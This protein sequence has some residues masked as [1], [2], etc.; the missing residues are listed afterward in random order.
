MS[1]DNYG[2]KSQTLSRIIKNNIIPNGF[3]LPWLTT[4]VEE[5]HTKGAPCDIRYD[6]TGS[7]HSRNI[8]VEILAAS[9]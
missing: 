6:A 7:V 1:N 4:I 2:V 3:Y 8:P 9:L 5:E